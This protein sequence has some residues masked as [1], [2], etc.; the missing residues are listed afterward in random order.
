MVPGAD[1]EDRIEKCQKILEGDPNSQI[2]A[3]LAEAFRRKGELDKAFRVCQ[4]GLRLHP[5]YG[6]AHI[7]MA[8]IN[9]DRGLYD[10]AE[11]EVK[12]A[13]DIE[14]NSRTI[15]LLLAEIYIFKG[16]FV[17]AVKLLRKLHLADPGN[18]QIKKLLDIAQRLPDEQAAQLE[19]KSLRS[20]KV[21]IRG[22][23]A[24]PSPAALPAA[25]KPNT[26]LSSREVLEQAVVLPG[27]DGALLINFEG[28][29]VESEWGTQLDATAC[30]AAMAEVTKLAN[31]EL[32]RTAFGP[33]NVVLIEASNS[34]YYL[35]RVQEGLFLFY[36]NG[37]TNLG[38]LRMKITS[39]LELYGVR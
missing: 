1:I 25:A 3:A 22:R 32:A 31:H 4:S 15:E 12:R 8:K 19:P 11:A 38:T 21:E 6:S 35:I 14:G 20:G 23:H 34:V 16:E 17:G 18:E 24:E 37:T 28:L 13:I 2:F 27:I 9:L 26:R 29:V 7:V 36:G 33:A 30:A 10:W 39:L 5:N